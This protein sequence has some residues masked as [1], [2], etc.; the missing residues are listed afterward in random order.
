[1]RSIAQDIL[2][3]RIILIC[4]TTKI[5]NKCPFKKKLKDVCLKSFPL[6]CWEFAIISPT[7]NSHFILACTVYAQEKSR[8]LTVAIN[9]Q[10]PR[11]SCLPEE[12]M[13][14]QQ[15]FIH[16][17]VLYFPDNFKGAKLKSKQ[18]L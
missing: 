3:M 8:W 15:K 17:F 4:S 1:M 11:F 7:M 18:G 5:R 16:S 14:L 6:L 12:N 2:N 10:T 9:T 13:I